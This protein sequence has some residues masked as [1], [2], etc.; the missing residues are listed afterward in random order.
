MAAALVRLCATVIR[1]FRLA[2][3]AAN[4]FSYSRGEARASQKQKLLIV[5]GADL[6]GG[7]DSGR[8]KQR[9]Y[10]MLPTRGTLLAKCGLAGSSGECVVGRA[11]STATN[12]IRGVCKV[13]LM[14]GVERG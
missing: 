1:M 9:P 10:G 13:P 8:S 6:P 2:S 11:G 4:R 14:S 7:R 5:A 3:I 12:E